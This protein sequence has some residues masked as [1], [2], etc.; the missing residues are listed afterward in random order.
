MENSAI[1]TPPG[2][3]RRLGGRRKGAGLT[4]DMKENKLFKPVNN[5]SLW[6]KALCL[7]EEE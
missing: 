7:Y 1:A 2:R 6:T 5:L 3:A 4:G